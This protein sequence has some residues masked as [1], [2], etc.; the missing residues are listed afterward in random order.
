MNEQTRWLPI[1][2]LFF[3]GCTLSLHIGKL[4]PSLPL[5]TEAFSLRLSQAGTLVATFSVLIGITGLLLGTVVARFGYVAFAVAGVA[6]AGV[7]SIIGAT[8]D[9]FS[10]LIVSRAIEGLGWIVAVVAIPS[11]MA[12]LATPRDTPVVLGIWGAFLPAGAGTMLLLTPF[13][14]S[15]GDWRLAWWV[16]AFA[17]IVASVIVYAIGRQNLQLYASLK[18]SS[19]IKPW[20]EIKSIRAWGLFFCF[21][22][23]S[24]Q[25]MAL[26]SFLPTL[27]MTEGAM[28]LTSASRWTALVLLT[29]V[30]GNLLAGR[31]IRRGVPV[32][33]LL[34]V[35][36]LSVGAAALITL[37]PLPIYIRICSAVVF[38]VT[39]GLIPGTLFATASRV[40]STPAATGILIGFMLQAAGLGQWMGPMLLTRLVEGTGLWW[41]GGLLLLLMAT[42][43]AIAAII[44]FRTLPG[45]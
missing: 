29:N 33:S 17:S 2:L 8:S 20:I 28:S 11:L 45:K 7:G 26:T 35:A 4:P 38:A 40:A 34:S 6:L 36:A 30:I 22:F 18:Q 12:R 3:C 19:T 43:G 37:L 14:Q 23:Y 32:S 1:W 24:F 41:T 44:G 10:M 31:L 27:F 25:F 15:A 13:L 5:L 9:S 16:A 39:G 42:L 21:F